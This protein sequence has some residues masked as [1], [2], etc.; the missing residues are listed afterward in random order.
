V[1][2]VVGFAA[3]ERDPVVSD[4]LRY[5]IAIEHSRAVVTNFPAMVES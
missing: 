5:E 4:R 1:R 2:E 3:G